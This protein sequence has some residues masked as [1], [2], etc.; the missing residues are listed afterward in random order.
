MTQSGTLY[1]HISFARAPLDEISGMFDHLQSLGW[2]E[3]PEGRGNPWVATFSK[4]IENWDSAEDQA[5]ARQEV[6]EVM[7][8]YWLDADAMKALNDSA[9]K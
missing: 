5:E 3:D 1:M 7:G 4:E 9:Q 6:R 2:V 8:Q